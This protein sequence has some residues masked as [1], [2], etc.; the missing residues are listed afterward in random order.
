[1]LRKI[2]GQKGGSPLFFENSAMVLGA[3]KSPFSQTALFF[4]YAGYA[5][6]YYFNFF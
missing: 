2:R 6:Y 3:A 4:G 5:L 1:M